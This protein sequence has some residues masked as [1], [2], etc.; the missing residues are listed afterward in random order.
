M[1]IIFHLTLPNPTYNMQNN[2]KPSFVVNCSFV[3]VVFVVQDVINGPLSTLSAM[4][5]VLLPR[6][7][8][9]P[10]V[11]RLSMEDQQSFVSCLFS[12]RFISWKIFH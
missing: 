3:V 8:P 7:K 10:E 5:E 1:T 2:I 11:K 6:I 9:R 12:P 4:L